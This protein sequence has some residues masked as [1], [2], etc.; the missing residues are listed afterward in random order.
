[1]RP[2]LLALALVALLFIGCKNDVSSGYTSVV[3]GTAVQVPAL[4]GGKIVDLRVDTGQRV[5]SGAILAI[6][7]T[8]DLI[9]QRQQLQAGLAELNVQQQLAQTN[10]KRSQTNV[11]YLQ[12]K[13]QRVRSLVQN[14]SASQQKFD[15]LTNLLHQAESAL[16]A[17]RQQLKTVNAKRGQLDAQLS[18]LNKKIRDAVIVAPVGGVISEK[19]FESGE[20][21]PPLGSLV[22][23]I[24]IDDVEVKIYV[25]EPT[26]PGIRYGQKVRVQVD[27]L[28][29]SL[30]GKVAWISPKAEFTPK[31]ILT[32]ETRTSL[33]YAVKID[34]PNPDGV[35]K[36]GMPVEVF[37]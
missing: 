14:N 3:E 30:D 32:P 12:E 29:R 36:H 10:V 9:F 18:G 24:N 8:A 15:D 37:F 22:E 35:L 1:M 20:A 2:V 34:V 26:L 31:S 16:T 13:Q 5:E 27:G 19:Y 7:D 33:V 21:I 17:A 4:T 28:E 6:V 25:T 11:S 23:I